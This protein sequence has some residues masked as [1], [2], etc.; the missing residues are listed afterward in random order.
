MRRGALPAGG[1]ELLRLPE[2]LDRLGQDRHVAASPS[3]VAAG[4]P[5]WAVPCFLRSW[6]SS[7]KRGLYRVAVDLDGLL[8]PRH[9]VDLLPQQVWRYMMMPVSEAP[10]FSR[11]RSAMPPWVTQAIMSWASV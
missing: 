5:Q 11:S 4:R 8:A 2:Q 1:L 7:T 6:G 3:L 10:S 9:A